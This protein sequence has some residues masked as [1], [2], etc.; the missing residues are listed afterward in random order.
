MNRQAYYVYF[1]PN[2]N[3]VH[4][5]FLEPA[6]AEKYAGDRG[7]VTRLTGNA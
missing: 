3:K 5:P 7:T 4:G 1:Y 6:D 2:A